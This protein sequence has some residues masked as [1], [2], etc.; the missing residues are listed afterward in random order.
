VQLSP[1]AVIIALL[2]GDETAG[3]AGAIVAVPSAV[4]ASVLINEYLRQMLAI[5][6]E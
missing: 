3:V 6:R 2:L 1:A 5:R 4:L